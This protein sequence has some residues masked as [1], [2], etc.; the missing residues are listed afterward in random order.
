MANVTQYS[1]DGTLKNYGREELDLIE[2]WMN[3]PFETRIETTLNSYLDVNRSVSLDYQSGGYLNWGS[4]PDGTLKIDL[5]NY[6]LWFEGFSSYA[7]SRVTSIQIL[8]KFGNFN[9]VNGD[10]LYSGLP[11]FSSIQDGSK[12]SLLGYGDPTLTTGSIVVVDASITKDFIITG[13]IETLIYSFVDSTYEAS[14]RDITSGGNVD[15]NNYSGSFDV[16]SGFFTSASF[17]SRDYPLIDAELL[18]NYILVENVY[19]P[20]SGTSASTNIFSGDDLITLT[21]TFGSTQ[22]SS[23]GNDTV[24]GSLYA[25]FIYGEQ[26]NDSIFGS[27]GNDFI[28]GGTGVDISSYTGLAKNYTLTFGRT[29]ATVI[30]RASDR[31]GI[32]TL[33]NIESIQFADSTLQ[34]LWFTEAG[35]LASNAATA[36]SFETLTAM[37]MAYFNRAPDAVGLYYWGS[38]VYQ[39]QTFNQVAENFFLAPETQALYP[40]PIDTQSSVSEM[41]GFINSVYQNVLNRTPDS[42]GL[43][44]W[45]NGLQTGSSTATGF[46]LQIIKAAVSPTGSPIDAAYFTTK[47]EVADHF[48]ITNGLTNVDQASE[49]IELFNS[50]YGNVPANLASAELAAINLADSYLAGIGSNPQMVVQLVGYDMA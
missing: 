4:L 13:Q 30:D 41:T 48:A 28:D 11:F 25:D 46:I 26:G 10:M 9:I 1:T 33:N 39:G 19:I 36:D 18:N 37:Y 32:D 6:T 47:G 2:P 20:I 29:G 24:S 23:S 35:S 38:N 3:V 49:V 40:N 12:I 34:T 31:D 17:D 15:F 5:D 27:K 43:N 8:D 7:G 16:T 21:G 42:E 14:V 22:Y 44:Y 50:T 45:L